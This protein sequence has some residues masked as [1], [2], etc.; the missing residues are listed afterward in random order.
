MFRR[1]LLTAGLLAI[2]TLA[3]TYSWAQSLTSS[4]EEKALPYSQRPEV[5]RFIHDVSRRRGLDQTWI[6][7]VLDQATYQPKIERLMTPRRAAPNTRDSRKDWEKYRNIFL[8]ADRLHLGAEFWKDNKI[9]LDRA[10]E[11]YHVDPAVI[12]GIIGVE[13]RYG[14]NTGSWKVLDSLVTLSFDYK[15]RAD[16]FKK[17]LEE[18]LVFLHQNQLKPFEVQ[19]SYAGAVGLPQFM[20]SSIKKYGVDFDGDGKI[21]I[22]KSPADTIGSIANYLHSMGWQEG[23]PMVIEADITEEQHK[24]YGGGTSARFQWAKLL[25]DGVN[26]LDDKHKYPDEM[27]V[28]VVDFPFYVPGTLEIDRIYRIGTKNF[29]A[30]LRYNPSYFY[31]GAVSELATAIA[32]VVG[33]TG[34]I[35]GEKIVPD[36]KKLSARKPKK[37]VSKTSEIV[38]KEDKPSSQPTQIKEITSRVSSLETNNNTTVDAWGIKETVEP[39]PL[40]P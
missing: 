20:P 32:E 37:T 12:I 13:T 34:L 40:K 28:F 2:S 24:K 31:A 6:A 33:E 38:Y 14:E 3:G 5:Q 7:T 4:K 16:F 39:I 11:I 27:Q 26:P 9:Y 35:D 17:E 10:K 23:L 36:K 1:S 25:K 22:N 15:R 19:G 29:T 30:V 8:G 18:F 21:D